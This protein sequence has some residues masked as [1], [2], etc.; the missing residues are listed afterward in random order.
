[1]RANTLIIL[2]LQRHRKPLPQGNCLS[3][4]KLY[5]RLKFRRWLEI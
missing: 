3:K 4:T 2:L 1:M 5:P